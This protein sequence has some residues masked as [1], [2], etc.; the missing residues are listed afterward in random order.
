MVMLIFVLFL[1]LPFIGLAL[2]IMVAVIVAH[3][4]TGEILNRLIIA[5]ICTTPLILWGWGF[6]VLSRLRAGFSV[7]ARRRLLVFYTLLLA[8][9]GI[10]MIV[11]WYRDGE[12]ILIFDIFSILIIVG[13]LSIPVFATMFTNPNQAE[14][15]ASEDPQP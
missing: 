8:Y 14:Q 10:W 4:T 1:L 3:G 7:S 5:A 11:P 12:R 2:F 15:I 13:V 9:C 6:R